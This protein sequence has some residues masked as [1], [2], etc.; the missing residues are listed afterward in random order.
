MSTRQINLTLGTAGHIDH[1][2]TAL[3]KCL[4]GCETDRLKAEKERG[5]SIELGFAPC[6]IGELEVGIVDVPGHENFIKTMVAGAAGIDAVIFVVAADDGIMPQTVEH[7]DIIS[8]LGVKDGIVA[9]TKADCVSAE[10]L[11]K[12]TQE[13]RAYLSGTFLKDAAVCPVS[14]LTG[15]GF[16]LFCDELKRL[17]R[18]LKP[19]SADGVFRLPVERVFSVKGY[20]T[21]VSG[22][23]VSGSLKKGEQVVLLPQGMAGRA[24]A[25]QVYNRNSDIAVCGQC[26]AINVPQWD[27]RRIERGNVVS[28]GKYFGAEQLYLCKLWMLSSGRVKLK[29]GSEIR[30]HTGTSE[31]NSSVYPLQDDRVEPGQEALVQIK[32]N[33]A[34]V[35][36]P[37]DYFI[38]RSLSPVHTIG[39]GTIIE[40]LQHRLKRTHPEVVDDAIVRADAVTEP[41]N[42][43]EYCIETAA[44]GWIDNDCLSL[45]TKLQP[46][47]LQDIVDK[48][49]EQDKVRRFSSRSIHADTLERLA[50]K[51]IEST[52]QFH[53]DNP[54]S[55]G[56]EKTRLFEMCSIEK[57]LFDE[58][59]AFLLAEGKLVSRK[60]RLALPGYSEQF[61]SEQLNLLSRVES[62]YKE[63]LFNPPN[64]QE[65]AQ[66]AGISAERVKE[67][68]RVLYEQQKLVKVDRD[69]FFHRDAVNEARQILIDYIK[70]QGRLES[71][72]FKYLLNTSRKFAI[73]LLDYFDGTGLLRREGNTRYLK[74][75]DAR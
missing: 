4:T 1:G 5:M 64:P 62:I 16:E 13:L 33:R 17:V 73:P 40:A 42:F 55:P 49:V 70:E 6:L 10:T 47:V 26:S 34:I 32:L 3:V 37:N 36:G 66:T 54:Q 19:K 58:M 43:A 35:A 72:R 30:F 46:L 41:L 39:G 68:V 53:R 22:I 23:P 60:S 25:I 63:K 45:R 24:K 69:L 27:Y 57:D 12:V 67:F 11:E 51:I 20:G 9:L 38:L 7:L 21:V 74:Q 52:E 75:S 29:S 71:V 18:R 50:G 15:K 56:V 8:L 61:S 48:L 65:I 28:V 59:I 2:K 14:S 31:V 44:N